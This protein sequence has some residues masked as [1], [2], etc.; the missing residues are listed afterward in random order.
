M[1]ILD[2]FTASKY[3]PSATIDHRRSIC[4]TCP[5]RTRL[6]RCK[7]CGCFTNVKA[8]LATEKCPI[9]KW[10]TVA[11]LLLLLHGVGVA[12]SFVSPFSVVTSSAGTDIYHTPVQISVTPNSISVGLNSEASQPFVLRYDMPPITD[13]T[14]TTY[15]T[16]HGTVQHDTDRSGQ[17]LT[18]WGGAF[19]WRLYSF[20]P[21]I[22]K[23]E[24]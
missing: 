2:L 1:P 15:Y 16:D 22:V 14:K 23:L 11:V 18:W 9:G 12:Q 4:N 21:D 10:G 3:A 17:S 7:K 13:G 8:I 19:V 5:Y 24:K 6:G 20:F